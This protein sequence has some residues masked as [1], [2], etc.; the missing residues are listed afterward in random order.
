[1]HAL[2]I[3]RKLIYDSYRE[4]YEIHSYKVLRIEMSL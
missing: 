4:S 2:D 3:I 1:M